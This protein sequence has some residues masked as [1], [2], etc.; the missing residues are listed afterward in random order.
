MPPGLAWAKG[1]TG[2]VIGWRAGGR[3]AGEF[4]QVALVHLDALYH[5]ALRLTRN[6][7]EAEDVVQ[8]TCLRALRAFSRFNPGTNCRAWL[9]T[10]LRNVFL[11]RVRTQG[12]E[13]LE[14]EPDR[15]DM[16]ERAT[17][18]RRG[19]GNPEEEFLQT[20]LHG[21]VDRALRTLPL[22]FREAIILVDLE[23]LSYREA[24]DVLDCPI[25]T[26]MSR[27][28]RGRTHLRQSLKRYAHEHGY[29]KE[30]E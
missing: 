17:E 24:A 26:V 14:A 27:L 7:A 13:V 21:D 16:A 15:L 29:V 9:F 22:P 10:I 2:S 19:A 5:F 4:E 23:G 20:V 11:N 1:F 6:R 25:G 3:D 18:A 30:D 12:R 28:S 8:E